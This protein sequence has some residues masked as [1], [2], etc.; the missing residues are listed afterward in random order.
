ML[1]LSTVIRQNILL[2]ITWRLRKNK[3]LCG[4]VVSCKLMS[5]CTW[6]A[7]LWHIYRF[8]R[9]K[10]SLSTTYYNICELFCIYYTLRN[11]SNYIMWHF[12]L[13]IKSIILLHVLCDFSHAKCQCTWEKYSFCEQNPYYVLGE[14]LECFY[15]KHKFVRFLK[16]NANCIVVKIGNFRKNHLEFSFVIELDQ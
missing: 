2:L 14:F 13:P 11:S 16:C 10:C 4:I 12:A 1:L 9:V 3:V 8:L 15:N 7:M 5:Y 6:F